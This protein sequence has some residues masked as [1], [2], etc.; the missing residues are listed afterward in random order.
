[1]SIGGAIMAFVIDD[2]R[3]Y[4]V[5]ELAEITG[6]T[7]TTL[8]RMIREKKIFSRKLGREYMING[9]ALK[10]YLMQE[11]PESGKNEKHG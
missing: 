9:K 3:F 1:M 10:N 8:R 5:E 6:I 4:R 2:E 11:S 7:K